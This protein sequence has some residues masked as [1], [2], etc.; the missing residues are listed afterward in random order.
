[1]MGKSKIGAGHKD[2]ARDDVTQ[3]PWGALILDNLAKGVCEIDP[4]P[5]LRCN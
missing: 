1:M 2:G 3:W 4:T 5:H